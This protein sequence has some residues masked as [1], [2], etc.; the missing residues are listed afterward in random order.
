M[1]TQ[2]FDRRQLEQLKRAQRE[3]HDLLPT[4]DAAEQCGVECSAFRQIARD[5][6]DRLVAI[7]QN[8][9]RDLRD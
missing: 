3:I 9:M 6:S 5:L 1:A 4:I 8:F 7:E 2:I